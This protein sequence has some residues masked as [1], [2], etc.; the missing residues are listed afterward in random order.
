[1]K[2]ASK[3]K[4]LLLL[5]LAALCLTGCANDVS[6]VF[7]P[8][9][10]DTDDFIDNYFVGHDDL[11]SSVTSRET[12]TLTSSD[13]FA[14]LND[15]GAYTGFSTARVK[16]P[17]MFVDS[18][19]R[20]LYVNNGPSADYADW[21]AQD[22]SDE[23]YLGV[24]FGRT[25]CLGTT[26][27]AFKHGVM[28]KLYDGQLHCLG[29]YSKARVQLT[30]EGYTTRFPKQLVSADYLVFCARWADNSVGLNSNDSVVSDITVSFFKENDGSIEALDVT[31]SAV[32]F[33][34][35]NGGNSTTLF[36]LKF[37]DV[38][39]SLDLGGVIGMGLS[40]SNVVDPAYTSEQVVYTNERKDGV[41]NSA[42]MLYEVMLLNSTWR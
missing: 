33:E 29:A 22:P 42:L 31:M 16:Y 28:S 19:G 13:I 34:R 9:P 25:L 24:S 20:S 14:G 2:S 38:L 36:G 11:S 1:M 40:F 30:S 27:E 7:G 39:A 35:N 32:P 6:E 41:I 8:S 10:F 18:E 4:S 26:D 23:D 15:S 21:N 5:P 37:S 17:G 12:R 3:S